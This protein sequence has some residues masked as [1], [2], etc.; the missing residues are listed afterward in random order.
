MNKFTQVVKDFWNDEEGLTA[1]EYA[2]AGSMVAAAV[3]LSF[4][5]LGNAVKGVIDGLT[6]NLG[7]GTGGTGGATT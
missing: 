1:V 7:T 5:S 6:G 3:V 4:Q 2:V